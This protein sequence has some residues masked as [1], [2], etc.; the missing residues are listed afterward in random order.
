MEA[1]KELE[2]KGYIRINVTPVPIAEF[3]GRGG[4]V[5]MGSRWDM[6]F[7]KFE[8]PLRP[9]RLSAEGW[10]RLRETVF[11]RDDYTCQYCGARG[12]ELE[13]DHVDPISRGGTNELGNLVTACRQ[14]NRSKRNKQIEK[15]RARES[16]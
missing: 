14:C 6:V 5:V 3:T 2:G 16:T 15:W 13:C 12:G 4:G 10:A 8:R 7:L 11:E 9:D 1:L